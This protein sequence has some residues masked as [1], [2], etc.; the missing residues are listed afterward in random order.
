MHVHEGNNKITNE[1]SISHLC[2]LDSNEIRLNGDI[3]LGLLLEKDPR[4]LIRVS[5]RVSEEL[6]TISQTGLRFAK[7]IKSEIKS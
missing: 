7:I 2:L 3:C 4:N 1:V 6:S 5:S